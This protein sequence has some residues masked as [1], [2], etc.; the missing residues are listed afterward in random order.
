M[1]SFIRLSF[2]RRS[3]SSSRA[4]PTTSPLLARLE[5]CPSICPPTALTLLVDALQ[6]FLQPVLNLRPVTLL[7][8][9]SDLHQETQ[10]VGATVPPV[11]FSIVSSFLLASTQ[12]SSNL[13]IH[14][15]QLLVGGLAEG[16][17]PQALKESTFWRSLCGSSFPQGIL[18]GT[19]GF[20]T[21]AKPPAWRDLAL[22]PDT[23]HSHPLGSTSRGPCLRHPDQ[24]TLSDLSV[25]GSRA[26]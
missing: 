15:F 12:F 8:S 4:F 2:P 19:F 18:P 3:H 5:I 6:A 13:S 9:L 24:L 10:L 1:T 25:L 26:Y 16:Y 17:P 7:Q 14:I 22:H 23:H 20:T 21:S 11:P